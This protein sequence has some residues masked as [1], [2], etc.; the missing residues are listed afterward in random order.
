MEQQQEPNGK[1]S[2]EFELVE[3]GPGEVVVFGDVAPPVEGV[4]QEER[5]RKQDPRQAVDLRHAVDGVACN[6]FTFCHLRTIKVNDGTVHSVEIRN[7]T[8]WLTFGH[9]L[10]LA[11]LPERLVGEKTVKHLPHARLF[12]VLRLAPVGAAG[13]RRR[14]RSRFTSHAAVGTEPNFFFFL[15]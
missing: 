7:E 11:F 14:R 9:G 1:D 3:V 13:P 15:E 5:H 10:S 6:E 4:E 8:S 2:V 12:R